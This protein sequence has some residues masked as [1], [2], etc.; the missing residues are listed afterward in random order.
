MVRPIVNLLFI[1]FNL[2]R[3]FG[4]AIIIFTILIKLLTWPLTKKQFHQSRLIR[5]LQPELAEI[6]KRCKGNRQLETL[7]TMDLYKRYNA[8]PFGSILT[9]IIQFPIFFALFS[10]INVIANP[11]PSAHLAGRAYSFVAYDGSL[12]KYIE[13]RQATYLTA[14]QNHQIPADQKP[15]YDFH[16]QLFGLINLESKAS[17]IL[18]TST[19]SWSSVFIFL[20]A[21]LASF[22]Q[23]LTARQQLPSGKSIKKKH[24]RDLLKDASTG[25]DIEQSDINSLATSQ[26]TKMM[27]IM[28]FMVVFNFHGAIP[29]YYLLNNIII[30]LQ[31]HVILKKTESDL[32]HVTDQ[33]ILKELKN[34]KE[35]KIIENKKTGTKITRIS[36][37]DSK[38]KRR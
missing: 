15:S 3:D 34:I 11:L 12:I 4:L 27:P 21:I 10:A 6:R 31:Q 7:Q 18:K 35:A 16:P 20:C 22:S 5:Q 9:L 38:K 14:L 29:F 33:A 26:M 30:F 19:R 23:Y 2:V 28:M 17:D 13:Q 25:K 1:I 37:K 24:F 36:A 8:K 32:D